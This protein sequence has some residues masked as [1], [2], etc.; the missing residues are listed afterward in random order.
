MSQRLLEILIPVETAD[1]L[2]ELLE[3]YETLGIWTYSLNQD[4]MLVRTLLPSPDTEA[5]SDAI[6]E[7]FG[8]HDGFR[9]LVYA[10]EAT[11]PQPESTEDTST[12]SQQAEAE[13][14]GEI[15]LRLGR[16]SREELYADVAPGAELS[17]TYFIMVFLSTIVAAIGLLFND[18][19]IIIGAM[20]IAPLLRPSIALALSVTLGDLNLIK[21]SIKTGAAGITAAFLISAAIGFTVGIDPEM[22]QVSVRTS[23]R[24]GHAI[25][26]LAAGVAG[27][28][29]F[30]T[31][32]SV[33]LIGVMVAV[34]LLPPLVTAGLLLG[35]DHWGLAGRA[36]IL[37]LTNLTGINLAS[38]VTFWVQGIRPRQWWEA[39]KAK[40]ATR[41][42]IIFWL[43]L[44][45]VFL[46]LAFLSRS[47]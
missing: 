36:A 4:L 41:F 22:A 17:A 45:F 18:V 29:A 16:I 9:V 23:I 35:A 43:L 21:Q 19:A 3:D 5:I 31:G 12:D 8:H 24:L 38:I 39:E 14:P 44:L 32:V 26:A 11:I 46:A 27:A 28:L 47:Q 40:R 34:A 10:I 33:A 30:T 15:K 25:L 2:R 1:N 6:V 42:A 20:V 37:F 13:T 7:Q